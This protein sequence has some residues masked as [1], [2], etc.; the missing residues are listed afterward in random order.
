MPGQVSAKKSLVVMTL[1]SNMA[2]R[3]RGCLPGDSSLGCP[4]CHG[5]TAGQGAGQG[6]PKHSPEAPMVVSLGVQGC[7]WYTLVLL[8]LLTSELVLSASP[9]RE[10]HLEPPPLGANAG[11]CS[12]VLG[13]LTSKANI[14]LGKM[15]LFL[16]P[17][18]KE[19]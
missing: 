2:R 8:L 1:A 6:V 15:W 11:R 14:A 12:E 7:L 19:I 16:W 18:Q 9:P 10:E 4:L 17:K 5:G 3:A 13:S